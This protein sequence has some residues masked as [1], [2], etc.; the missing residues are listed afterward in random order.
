ME[1]LVF[2]NIQALPTVAC[3]QLDDNGFLMCNYSIIYISS[4]WLNKAFSW[5][6]AFSV[7][8]TPTPSAVYNLQ[9]SDYVHCEEEAASN[10][11]ISL[12]TYT[13]VSFIF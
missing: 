4:T 1:L 9:S 5:K 2:T 13:S 8:E 11:G 6:V 10:R 12:H 7:T 3:L